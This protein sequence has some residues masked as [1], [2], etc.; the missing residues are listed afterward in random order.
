MSEGKYNGWF[1]LERSLWDHWLKP[2]KPFSKFEAWVDLIKSANHSPNKVLLKG[3]MFDIQR[4]QQARSMVT[5][6]NNWGWSRAKVKRFLNL[7]I[8]EG[9]I[10]QQ[11]NPVTSIITICNYSEKQNNRAADSAANGTTENHQTNIK[12]NINNN[13]N[14]ENNENISAP[15]SFTPDDMKCADYIFQKMRGID[16]NFKVN[17]LDDWANEVRLIREVDNRDHKEICSIFNYSQSSDH[18]KKFII[19]PKALRVHFSEI[20]I[21]SKAIKSAEAKLILPRIDFAFLDWC[22]ENRVKYKLPKPKKG[23]SPENFRGR[24]QNHVNKLNEGIA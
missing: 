17:N 20:V 19:T 3:Q 24:V 21:Q 2:E 7:L 18:Y 16:S 9:K 10:V 15:A 5:L 22:E 8:A 4:G 12:Q 11:T 13:V 1:S 14:N 23:E 6:A